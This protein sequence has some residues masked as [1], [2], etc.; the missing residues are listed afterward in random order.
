MNLPVR[1][2]WYLIAAMNLGA[3]HVDT[4]NW[5]W[6]SN[7]LVFVFAVWRLSDET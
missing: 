5:L 2:G 4:S 1:R 3:L 7:F 6:V